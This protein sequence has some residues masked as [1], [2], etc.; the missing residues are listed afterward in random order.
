M[1]KTA[2]RFSRIGAAVVTLGVALWQPAIGK[3][4]GAAPPDGLHRIG[5]PT[6]GSEKAFRPRLPT[7]TTNR[8][9][10]R[11][12]TLLSFGTHTVDLYR[13]AA[14][15]VDKILNGAKPA[16]LSVEQP[17]RFDL[18]VNLKTAKALGIAMPR[19]ILLRADRVI[20]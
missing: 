6:A 14:A 19:A 2:R 16:D 18:A 17:S 15:Y 13:R 9:Y 12:G 3:P 8:R 10:A 7:K 4:A 5:Y 11:E 20:E 1:P